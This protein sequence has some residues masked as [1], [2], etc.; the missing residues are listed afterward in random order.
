MMNITIN[1]KNR[2][3]EMTKAFEKKASVYGSEEYMILQAARKDY[4]SYKPVVK[5]VNTGDR[6]KGLTFEYMEKYI[7]AHDVEVKTD[8]KTMK[9]SEAFRL[10]TGKDVDDVIVQSTYGEIKSWFLEI[11]PEVKELACKTKNVTKSRR[12]VK[13]AA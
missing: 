2:T 8:D 4:P 12:V 3:I 11:Y 1:A 7:A 5:K 13:A 9:A 6:M 10:M